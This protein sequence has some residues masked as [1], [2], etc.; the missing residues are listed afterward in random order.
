MI[1][2]WLGV[3]GVLCNG[4]TTDS[5]SVCEGS[6]PSTPV[7]ISRSQEAGIFYFLHIFFKNTARLAIQILHFNLILW[8]GYF[9]KFSI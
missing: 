1:L 4:S 7:F 2:E 8:L 5:G 3:V 9:G 6:N